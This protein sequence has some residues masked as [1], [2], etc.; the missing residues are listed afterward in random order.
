MLLTGMRAHARRSSTDGVH[1]PAVV[2]DRRASAMRFGGPRL[3]A[4]LATLLAFRLLPEGFANRETL[5][6]VDACSNRTPAPTNRA[7]GGFLSI[8]PRPRNRSRS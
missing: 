7:A 2:D 6:H 4:L 1:R 8:D 5:E 3:Q